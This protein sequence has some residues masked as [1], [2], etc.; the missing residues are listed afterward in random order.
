[1]KMISNFIFLHYFK[2]EDHDVQQL[3]TTYWTS[4][5]RQGCQGKIVNCFSPE[6]ENTVA[7]FNFWDVFDKA[8]NGACVAL[9]R[10]PSDKRFNENRQFDFG[11][12]FKLCDSLHYLA[13]EGRGSLSSFVGE[14]KEKVAKCTPNIFIS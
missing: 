8:E 7:D 13:C 9:Q 6:R 11:P 4:M 2:E 5:T 12:T 1:M 14:K 3:T 10:L